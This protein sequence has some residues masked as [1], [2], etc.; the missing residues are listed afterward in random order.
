MVSAQVDI[1]NH[2]TSPTTNA[3]VTT[4]GSAAVGWVNS[5]AN[6][7]IN[8]IPTAASAGC[9]PATSPLGRRI[10]SSTDPDGRIGHSHRGVSVAIVALFRAWCPATTG[11]STPVEHSVTNA[12][13]GSKVPPG[14]IVR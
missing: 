11:R 5:S 7:E 13:L 10:G 2:T 6:Q 12:T 9:V 3:D 14:R 8:Q 4:I 1:T